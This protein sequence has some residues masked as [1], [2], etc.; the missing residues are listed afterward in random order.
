MNFGQLIRYGIS[1]VT[2]ICINILTLYILTDI[3]GLWYLMS[4]VLAFCVTLIVTFSLQ[5]YW[6]FKDRDNAFVTQGAR[7]ALVALSSL[8]AGTVL[9]YVAV[10]IFGFWYLGSQAVIMFTLAGCTF[11]A[12]K[13]FTFHNAVGNI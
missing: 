10:D 6:T 1:G 11:L 13:Y 3:V 9:L 2:G 12:N 8:I 5:K 7:Y 4:A